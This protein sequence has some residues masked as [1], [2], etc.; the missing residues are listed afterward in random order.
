MASRRKRRPQN[1]R[2]R[3]CRPGPAASVDTSISS[4][5]TITN[6][7]ELADALH[8]YNGDKYVVMRDQTIIVDS[9]SRRVVVV[10][11]TQG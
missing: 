2:S 9:Q 5:I 4:R 6:L 8:G 1:G 7:L 3:C 11:P 10:I